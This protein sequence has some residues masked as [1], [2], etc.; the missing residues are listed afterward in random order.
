LGLK[1]GYANLLIGGLLDAN[2]EIGVPGI[3]ANQ[4]KASK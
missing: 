1:S 3:A 2:R 4:P